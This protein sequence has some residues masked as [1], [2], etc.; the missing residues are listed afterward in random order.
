MN[1]R[2]NLYKVSTYAKMMGVQRTLVYYWINTKQVPYRIIDG[3]YF[4]VHKDKVKA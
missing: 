1:E 4:I 3:M 2:E